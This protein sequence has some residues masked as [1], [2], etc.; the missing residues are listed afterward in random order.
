MSPILS[1]ASPLSSKRS[2]T[3]DYGFCFFAIYCAVAIL[4]A[5]FPLHCTIIGLS[6]S[7][8]A[9][10][11]AIMNATTIVSAPL[12]IHLSHRLVGARKLL[13]ITAAIPPLLF[14]GF[15]GIS[16]FLPVLSLWTTALVIGVSTNNL[17]DIQ[18]LRDSAHG[19][20]RY[21][22]ARVWGS[23]GFIVATTVAGLVLDLV[24]PASIVPLAV[25]SYLLLFWACVRVAHRY[26]EHPDAERSGGEQV[27][28]FRVAGRFNTAFLMLTLCAAFQWASHS[29][30]YVFLSVYLRARGWEGSSISLAWNVGVIAEITLFAL[31][32]RWERVMSIEAILV[33]STLATVIRWQL[34]LNFQE[35]GVIFVAQA[36]HAFSFGSF[37]LASLRLVYKVVPESA[38]RRAQAYFNAGS[39][40]FGSLAGRLFV[41]EESRFVERAA[42]LN[43]LFG[44]SVVFSMGSV[45]AAGV[46]YFLT[47]QSPN[48]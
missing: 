19:D 6:G 42:D 46:L 34:L 4:I 28:A 5:F 1:A 41:G 16:T 27:S 32:A 47:R 43:Q 38:A 40:G 29:T 13:L 15:L 17:I 44:W 14:F 45:I 9:V 22:R 20:L 2:A 25:G 31:F 33:L 7:Q 21:E 37:F 35:P 23:I 8:I 24:G 30:L 36:F 39:M 18:A 48:V 10:L 12:A 3:F 26:P 11:S